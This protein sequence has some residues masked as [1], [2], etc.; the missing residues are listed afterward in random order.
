MS[1]PPDASEQR[2]YARIESSLACSLATAADVVDAAVVNLSKGGAAILG[3]ENAAQVG[4]KVT[5]LLER[6]EGLVSI[7]LQCEVVRTEQRGELALY[8]VQFDPLPPDA[9]RELSVLLQLIAGGRGSGRRE[10]PRVSARVA[11]NCKTEESF[12]AWLNDLSRGGLSVRC[13]KAVAVGGTIELSF[14]AP[15]LK[16]LVEITGEVVSCQQAGPS[17]WRLG[18]RFEPVGEEER[19][20]VSRVLDT[21]LGISLPQGEVLDEEESDE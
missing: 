4:D 11:V 15:G 21:L 18:V 17:Q 10:H 3:P 19:A 5:V 16:G 14:G 7:A 20:Q 8:G 2:K 13:G 12:R 9:E 1:P 6:A